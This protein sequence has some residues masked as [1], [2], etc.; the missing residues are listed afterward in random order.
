MPAPVILPLP[1]GV[2][3]RLAGAA[4][5]VGAGQ[6]VH[7][8]DPQGA[9]RTALGQQWL[10]GARSAHTVVLSAIGPDLSVVID[11][12]IS[13]DILEISAPVEYVDHKPLWL[14]HSVPNYIHSA[15]WRVRFE[16]QVDDVVLAEKRGSRDTA[17]SLLQKLLALTAPTA[18]GQPPP[19]L[20]LICGTRIAL[21]GYLGEDPAPRIQR[22]WPDGRVRAWTATIGFVEHRTEFR[23][24][25]QVAADGLASIATNF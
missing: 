12:P 13:P 15:S 9:L 8:F 1:I 24:G 6:F 17:Q 25:T 11:F 22:R 5:Q 16:A 23:T 7:R 19:L 18:R 3:P 10:A 4:R 2:D 20:H 14:S 21:A